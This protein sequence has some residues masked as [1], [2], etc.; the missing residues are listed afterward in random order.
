MVL[1]HFGDPLT[2]FGDVRIFINGNENNEKE[3]GEEKNCTLQAGPE[4]SSG[5]THA[6]HK[7]FTLQIKEFP[8]TR[9]QHI[10]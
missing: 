1:P 6:Q 2:R 8:L 5:E 4:A 9:N 3:E 7:V 10:Q